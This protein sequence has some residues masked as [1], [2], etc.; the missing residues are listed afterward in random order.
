[1][2]ARPASAPASGAAP[3]SDV[4]PSLVEILLELADRAMDQHF[5]RALGAAKRAGDLLV[6]HVEGEAHDQ[7]GLPVVGQVRDAA[8]HF[9]ELLASLDEVVGAVHLRERT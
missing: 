1:M 3:C 6:V 2:P 7:S 9:A 4:P 8:Q 5:G